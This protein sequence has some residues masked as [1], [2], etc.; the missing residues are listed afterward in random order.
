[1]YTFHEAAK[2]RKTQDMANKIIL[3]E[4]SFP[5]FSGYLGYTSGF[6]LS[7]MVFFLIVVSSACFRCWMEAIC[8]GIDNFSDV[9]IL[10]CLFIIFSNE[11]SSTLIL[12]YLQEVSNFLW[13][14][15]AKCNFSYPI[16]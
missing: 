1:M 8:W 9:L 4:I 11:L 7:C 14:T 3:C 13:C 10:V 2:R 5:F 12:G 15:R 6:S 16:K